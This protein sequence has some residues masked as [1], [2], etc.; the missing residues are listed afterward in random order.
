[1]NLNDVDFETLDYE[2]TVEQPGDTGSEEII[3]SVSAQVGQRE[4]ISE[5]PAQTEPPQNQEP[6]DKKDVLT[7]FLKFNGIKDPEHIKFEDEDGIIKEQNWNDLSFE[8]K[9]NI[10]TTSY[11]QPERDLDEKEI[12]FVN[13]LRS[14]NLTPE[15]YINTIRQQAA[16]DYADSLKANPQ[17]SIDDLSDDEIFM[18]DLQDKIDDVTDEE[19]TA[20]LAKA[21]EDPLFEKR[22]AGMRKTLKAQEEAY[23]AQLE[24][25]ENATREEQFNQFRDSVVNSIQSFNKVGDLDINLEPEDMEDIAAFILDRDDTGMSYMGRALNNPQT[26][27]EMAWWTLK[28][29]DALNSISEYFSNEIKNVR[30]M[31][32]QKGLEDGKKGVSKVVTK[33]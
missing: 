17:Y 15:Q 1:M 27:V 20:A 28:G 23:K 5:P 9:L 22:V 8:E 14:K 21:K 12:A 26:L 13:E 32:Y 11:Q 24:A 25:Q 30:Q 10:L 16:Q 2:P 4:V 31:S 33:P 18:L 29:R 3:D 6:N 19:L 7:E